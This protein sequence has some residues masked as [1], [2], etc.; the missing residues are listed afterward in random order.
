MHDEDEAATGLAGELRGE[1]INVGDSPRA[2][3]GV[4]KVLDLVGWLDEAEVEREGLSLIETIDACHI[5][6]MSEATSKDGTLA[7]ITSDEAR[8]IP[9]GRQLRKE[10]LYGLGLSEIT[11]WLIGQMLQTTLEENGECQLV[12]F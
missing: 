4:G 1:A 12:G 2:I 3:R 10:V 6:R 8:L 9:H 7:R 5:P 11:L